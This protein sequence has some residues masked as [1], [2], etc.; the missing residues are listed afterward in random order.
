MRHRRV[1]AP[2]VLSRDEQA[3]LAE[4]IKKFA[5]A[6]A[7][8]ATRHLSEPHALARFYW[9]LP[10]SRARLSEG[11]GREARAVESAIR[12]RGSAP[13]RV[14]QISEIGRQMILAGYEHSAVQPFENPINEGAEDEAIKVIDY[15]MA[16]SRL[17]RAVPANLLLRTLKA[18]HALD[19]ELLD[20]SLISHLFEG[21]DLFRWRYADDEK[22]EELLVSSRLQI[23]A[24]LICNRRLGS[25]NAEASRIIELIRNAHRAGQ[26]D[27]EET[28]FVADIVFAMGPDGP[29]GDRYRECYAEIARTLTALRKRNGVQNARLMLQESTLRR[30]AVFLQGIDQT[31]GP[32]S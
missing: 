32:S 17:Y 3:L 13:I 29:A 21:Q 15:V 24:E 31:T 7:N 2:A 27:H 20:L 11:L 23:E 16:A 18:R 26:E 28:R 10:A 30:K 14:Q 8:T 22:A 1:E 9:A 6:A 25:A 4:L 19:N 5:P 12:G